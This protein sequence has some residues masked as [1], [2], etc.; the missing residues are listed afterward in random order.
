MVPDGRAFSLDVPRPL[1]LEGRSPGA[2]EESWWKAAVE[3]SL[4]FDALVR[5]GLSPDLHP[6]ARGAG[7]L[8]PK[9]HQQEEGKQEA[10]TCRIRWTARHCDG[11]HLVVIRKINP[12]QGCHSKPLLAVKFPLSTNG[13]IMMVEDG[14]KSVYLSQSSLFSGSPGAAVSI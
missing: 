8:V 5:F 10:A 1:C 11:S 7:G 6:I 13:S 12:L 3:E 14:R 9:T 2:P 4:V